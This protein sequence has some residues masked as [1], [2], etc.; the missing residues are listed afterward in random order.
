MIV[1]HFEDGRGPLVVGPGVA[2]VLPASPRH[3][4]AN[5]GAAPARMFLID[6]IPGA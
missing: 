1:Y 2:F 5:E 6:A 3:R 4:G